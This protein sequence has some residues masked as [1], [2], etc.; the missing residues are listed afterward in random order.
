ML[1]GKISRMKHWIEILVLSFL[2]HFRVLTKLV[3]KHSNA[4]DTIRKA[5]ELNRTVNHASSIRH[6]EN[7]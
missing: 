5:L 2:S 7:V 1:S 3:D 6:V 4:S